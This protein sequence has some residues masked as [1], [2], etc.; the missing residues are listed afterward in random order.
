MHKNH[1]T[2]M[3][4]K[5]KVSNGQVRLL[6]TTYMTHLENAKVWLLKIGAK[7]LA[8]WLSDDPEEIKLLSTPEFSAMVHPIATQV[9]FNPLTV[10]VVSRRLSQELYVEGDEL[11]DHMVVTM[12]NDGLCEYINEV[13]NVV[14][15]V[16][17]VIESSPFNSELA[18]FTC[19]LMNFIRDSLHL[20][21]SKVK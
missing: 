20:E 18:A 13:K 15:G 8:E 9:I 17:D 2:D 4:I 1:E 3:H 14:N 16:S 10:T 5:A 7:E 6:A 12:L 21:I 11:Q 19:E